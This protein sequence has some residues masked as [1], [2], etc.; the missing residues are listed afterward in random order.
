MSLE[1]CTKKILEY[2]QLIIFFFNKKKENFFFS[3]TNSITKNKHN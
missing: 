1:K 2:N 3:V